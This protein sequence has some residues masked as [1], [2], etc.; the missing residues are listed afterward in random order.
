MRLFA[1]TVCLLASGALADELKGTLKERLDAG[2][3]SYLR[4]A[5][6][7]GEVWAAVPQATLEVGKEV[8]VEV[9]TEMRNFESKTLKRTWA[10]LIFGTVAGAPAAAPAPSTPG[11]NPHEQGLPKTSPSTPTLEGKVLETLNAG[12]YTYLRLETKQGETWAATPTNTVSKGATV[13]VKNPQPM[14]GF[15]SPSLNRTFERIVFGT[16]E[17]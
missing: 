13:R 5:T 2:G 11:V 17:Q 16:L 9:Q 1:L 12:T 8:S 10:S 3:Y 14:D 7:K 15:R 4:I 6:P